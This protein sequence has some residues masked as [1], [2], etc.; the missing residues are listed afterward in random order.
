MWGLNKLS[1]GGNPAAASMMINM[2]KVLLE[3]VGIQTII[4]FTLS[5]TQASLWSCSVDPKVRRL[6]QFWLDDP[7]LLD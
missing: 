4:V 1:V 7:L 5:S 2:S 3:K 6:C